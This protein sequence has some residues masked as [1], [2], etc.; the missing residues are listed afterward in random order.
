MIQRLSTRPN[1]AMRGAGFYNENSAVQTATIDSIHRVIELAA[2][3]VAIPVNANPIRVIDYGCSEGRNSLLATSPIIRTLQQRNPDAPVVVYRND[4]AT[5]DF[6]SL[7]ANL[8]TNRMDQAISCTGHQ[9]AAVYNMAVG[10]SFFEQVVPSNSIHLGLSTSSIHWL[11]RADVDKVSADDVEHALATQANRDWRTF[12]AHRAKEIRSGGKLVVT[13]PGRCR[14]ASLFDH[15]PLRLIN[16]TIREFVSD[17]PS[18]AESLGNFV[19][20]VYVRTLDEMLVPLECDPSLASRFRVERACMNEQP[21]PLYSQF[22]KSKNVDVYAEKCV[23]F[24][25]AFSENAVAERGLA[26][27]SESERGT[28][29]DAFYQVMLEILR[30][31][32]GCQGATRKQILLKLHRR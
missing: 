5:N 18:L 32:P 21:C 7:F 11:S 1:F 9:K 19:M 12:L 20:P 3:Q 10:R 29:I 4:L 2:R 23:S 13:S 28:L 16:E 26:G 27:C 22:R 31:S 8:A 24:I 6:N 15:P 30:R 17:R 25:R 14:A